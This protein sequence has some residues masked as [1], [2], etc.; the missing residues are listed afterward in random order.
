MKMNHSLAD[1]C[2]LDSQLLFP[3]AINS[4]PAMFLATF[5]KLTIG[6]KR[7]FRAVQDQRQGFQD[8]VK[9]ASLQWTDSK[10]RLN[11]YTHF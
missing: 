8:A 3:I 6:L 4:V 2:L 5:A 1:H 9:A 11:H 10:T 7:E